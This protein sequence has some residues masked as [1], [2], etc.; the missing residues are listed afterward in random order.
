MGKGKRRSILVLVSLMVMALWLAACG[1]KKESGESASPATETVSPAATTTPAA[2]TATEKKM[3]DGMGHEVVVPANPKNIIASY[4]EDYLVALGV[5]PAAQ[6]SVAN[7]IQDY[8]QDTLKGIPTIAYDLPYEAVASFSPDLLIIGSNSSVDGGKYDEYAKIA[9]TFVLGDEVNND[10]RKALL[11]I[12]EV[13]NKSGEAQKVLDDYEQKVADAKTKLQAAAPDQSVAAI[14]LVQKQFYVVSDKMSSGAVLYNDLGMKVPNVVK[15]I[16]ASGKG[17]WNAISLEKLADLDADN[18]ILVNSD[19]AT[20]SEALNDP[21]WKSVPAVK[22]GKVFEY[23][24]SSSWLYYGP[25]ASSQMVDNVL[26]SIA[27]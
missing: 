16:S 1:D 27:K 14:W 2:E 24:A 17:N 18:I 3:T 10:W 23:P 13:L 15:E 12:G 8:L 21:L 19:K 22:N 9:P 11:K 5:K 20:G 25:I 7:G 4:L 26:E 6:W